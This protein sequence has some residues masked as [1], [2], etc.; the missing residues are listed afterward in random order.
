MQGL[1][2]RM[3]CVQ[4]EQQ[5]EAATCSALHAGRVPSGIDSSACGRV[6]DDLHAARASAAAERSSSYHKWNQ[7]QARALTDERQHTKRSRCEHPML[8]LRR[9][10][11]ICHYIRVQVSRGR[12]GSAESGALGATL[13]PLQVRV[14]S[15]ICFFAMRPDFGILTCRIYFAVH[16][17]IL[18]ILIC[19]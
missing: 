13:L 14:T 7:Q 18:L 8:V 1:L 4:T 5:P 12:A 15:A 10:L 16:M 17:F 3:K 19:R 11:K 2:E 6:D 9:T